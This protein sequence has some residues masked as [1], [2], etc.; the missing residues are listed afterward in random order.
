MPT[1]M[2][3]TGASYPGEA[4]NVE[5]KK[6]DGVSIVPSFTGEKI[7]R[8]A[9]IFYEY[10]SGKAIQQGNMK[11]VGVKEW[12]L[13]DLSNDRTETKNLIKEQPEVAKELQV[14]WNAWYTETTGL[15]YEEEKERKKKA[16]KE[17]NKAKAEKKSKLRKSANL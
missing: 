10:G 5:S 6:P 8:D 17:S 2:E 1:L 15:N 13:Y 11:L 7:N 16:K 12:E 14:K 3:L 4:K 9:P